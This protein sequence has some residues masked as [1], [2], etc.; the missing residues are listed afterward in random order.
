M[1]ATSAGPRRPPD[2]STPVDPR[3]VE[4]LD[5]LAKLLAREYVAGPPG[6]PRSEAEPGEED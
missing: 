5:H 3:L 1:S 6:P 2:P 4:L